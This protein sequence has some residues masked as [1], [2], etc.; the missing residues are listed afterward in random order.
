MNWYKKY[1]YAWTAK[2]TYTL[3]ELLH[4]LKLFGVVY[5]KKGKGDHSIYINTHN[6]MTSAIPSG[7]GGKTIAS[8]TLTHRILPELGIPWGV[9]SSIGKRPKKKDVAR[10]QDQLP[11]NQKQTTE[12]EEILKPEE[13][14]EWQKQPWYQKQTQ[15]VSSNFNLSKK[16]NA[17]R[18]LY[19]QQQGDSYNQQAGEELIKDWEAANRDELKNM[20]ALAKSKN[21][22]AMKEY[23]EQLTQQG[24]DRL[25]VDKIMT[26]AMYKVK[27]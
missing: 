10:I 25:L 21:F 11:W 6:N 27:L 1:L 22:K 17:G 12:P 24:Y 5:Y 9:W 18:G 19:N 7:S 23:G 15:I 3:I 2:A 4:K 14:P 26:A 13:T 8:E 16:K 20:K